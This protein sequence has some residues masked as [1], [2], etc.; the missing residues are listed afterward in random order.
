VN[1]KSSFGGHGIHI[2]LQVQFTTFAAHF[3]IR[4]S[5]LI[6]FSFISTS[7]LAIMMRNPKA[8][9]KY[10]L[11]GVIGGDWNHEKKVHCPRAH[12]FHLSRL[13]QPHL[14][15]HKFLLINL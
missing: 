5:L 9:K 2:Q 12:S 7:M 1:E 6:A 14:V 8:I 3:M 4:D 15:M 11:G 13:Y 10:L